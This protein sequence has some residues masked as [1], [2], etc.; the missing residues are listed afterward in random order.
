MERHSRPRADARGGRH[1]QRAALLVPGGSKVLS[2]YVPALSGAATLKLQTLAPTELVEDTEVWADV[3]VFNLTDGSFVVLD[4]LVA[5]THVTIPISAT[6]GGPPARRHSRS[7]GRARDHPAL[8]L[9]GRM[10]TREFIEFCTREEAR[11]KWYAGGP[12]RGREPAGH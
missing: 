10:T 11:L 1:G 12:R 6:G 4:G 5:S 9:E 7:V 2:V 8:L 3:S